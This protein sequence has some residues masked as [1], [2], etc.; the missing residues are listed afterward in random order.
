MRRLSPDSTQFGTQPASP[1]FQN[2]SVI[3]P[4]VNYTLVHGIHSIKLGY[5]YQAINTQINDYNPELR[6]E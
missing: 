4:K 1:Q 3:N 6:P 5:E 2:P